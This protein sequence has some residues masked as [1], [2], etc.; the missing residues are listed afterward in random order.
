MTELAKQLYDVLP[1]RLAKWSSEIADAAERTVPVPYDAFSW[2]KIIAGIIDRE[3]L[4]G[5]ALNP[6]GAGGTGDFGHG[7]GLMQIDDRYHEFA[8]TGN[9]SDASE[10][11]LYGATYF[12]SLYDQSKGS[13]AN[14]IAAY[15][16]G[17][18]A[19]A[20]NDPDMYTTGGDYSKDV[21]GRVAS[22]T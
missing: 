22:Y 11:I 16:A 13:L 15:N 21:L 12:R 18:Q 8:R 17:P 4:G 1:P 10:N 6:P 7:K 9:W 19:L 2:G 5:S 3:S 14:A 20:S